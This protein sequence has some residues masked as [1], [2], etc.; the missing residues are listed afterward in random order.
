MALTTRAALLLEQ[1]TPGP[2]A[3]SRP[4]EIAEIDLDPPGAEE[5]LVKIRAAALCHTDLSFVSGDRPKG[6]PMVLGHE[7]CGAIKGSIDDVKLGNLTGLLAELKP[8]AEGIAGEKSSKNQAYVNAVVEANVRK[9]VKDLRERS[10]VLA[11]L[12]KEG[13]IKIVGAVYS[14]KTGKVTLLD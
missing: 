10:E 1:G 3:E 12:E 2:Y 9:T 7:A 11:G 4:I 5:V 14:L 8:A 13:K 6:M